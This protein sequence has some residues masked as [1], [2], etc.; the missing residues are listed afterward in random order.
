MN[1]VICSVAELQRK[2]QDWLNYREFTDDTM[3]WSRER[4]LARKENMCDDA[5]LHLTT[6][7]NLYELVNGNDEDDLRGEL[8]KL[9][10]RLG[11]WWE[12][13]YAW[14]IHFYPLSILDE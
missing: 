8:N 9:L 1:E 6:E 13:G 11:Y 2:V 12:H 4:W 10:E 3:F 5:D 7:G 14:S